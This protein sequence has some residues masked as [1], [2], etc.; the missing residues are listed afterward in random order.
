MY[1]FNGALGRVGCWGCG[2]CVWGGAGFKYL[3]DIMQVPKV[4]LIYLGRV[5]RDR[6]CPY[7]GFLE[8]KKTYKLSVWGFVIFCKINVPPWRKFSP[9][10]LRALARLCLT[11]CP[12][13]PINCLFWLG[14]W[15]NSK[16]FLVSFYLSHHPGEWMVPTVRTSQ[17][18]PA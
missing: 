3:V 18:P 8:L 7:Y 14:S 17:I 16:T 5:C 4:L 15:L 1:G 12:W 10:P 9:S 2:A 6:E 13:E 11:L